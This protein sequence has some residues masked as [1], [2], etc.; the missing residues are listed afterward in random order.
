MSSVTFFIESNSMILR[1]WERSS[2][3]AGRIK[4]QQT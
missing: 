4:K 3:W 2:H 1:Y